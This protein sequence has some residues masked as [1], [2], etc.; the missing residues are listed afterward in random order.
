[1]EGV[2]RVWIMYEMFHTLT[3]I[4]QWNLLLPFAFQNLV[5]KAYLEISTRLQIQPFQFNLNKIFK[6]TDVMNSSATGSGKRK[7]DY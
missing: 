7:E 5:S 3:S 2:I 4:L 1:M 6:Q